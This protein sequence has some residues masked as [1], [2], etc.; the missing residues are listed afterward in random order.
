MLINTQS[1]YNQVC[2]SISMFCLFIY[3]FVCVLFVCH[4]LLISTLPG[5]LRH[6]L[7]L[8]EGADIFE[9]QLHD[10]VGHTCRTEVGGLLVLEVRNTNCRVIL[11]SVVNEYD[12]LPHTL[13]T[14]SHGPGPF[15]HYRRPAELLS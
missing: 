4:C 8:P 11:T 6:W 5:I 14:Y 9:W 2:L 13:Q 3:L 7:C 12:Y 10:Y 1:L 15:K